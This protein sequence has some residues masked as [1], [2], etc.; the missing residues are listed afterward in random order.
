MPPTLKCYGIHADLVQE[1]QGYSFATRMSNRRTAQT[2][3][4]IHGVFD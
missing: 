2:V 3:D 1:A 4:L